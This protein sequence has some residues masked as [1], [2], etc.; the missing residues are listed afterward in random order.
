MN[1]FNDIT[2]YLFADPDFLSGFGSVLDIGGTLVE[3]NSQISWR[4]ADRCAAMSD[5]AAIAE[6]FKSSI[7]KIEHVN[8][9]S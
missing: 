2:N 8:L 7:D 3:Y 5:W 4:E 6:D 9:A 1:K